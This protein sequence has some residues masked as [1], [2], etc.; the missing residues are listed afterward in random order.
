MCSQML[1]FRLFPRPGRRLPSGKQR[2]Q[3]NPQSL[4]KPWLLHNVDNSNIYYVKQCSN[5]L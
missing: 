2:H 1:F 5:G 3:Q 4:Q